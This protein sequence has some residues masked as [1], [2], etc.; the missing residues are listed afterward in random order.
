MRVY[1]DA[2]RISQRL[3]VLPHA[4]DEHCLCD[5]CGEERNRRRDLAKQTP[6]P[7]RKRLPK[8]QP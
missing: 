4:Y 2:E 8:E 5:N 7:L 3:A 1:W 6:P